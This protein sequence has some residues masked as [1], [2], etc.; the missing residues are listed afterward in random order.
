MPSDIRD[1]I[2]EETVY[3]VISLSGHD[4]TLDDLHACHLL[5]NKGRVISKF[6]ERKL[7]YS[8]Q[9]RIK[10]LQEKFLKLSKLKFSGKLFNDESMY[11]E[12]QQLQSVTKIVRLAP[13]APLFNVGCKFACSFPA[14]T[15]WESYSR[16]GTT[17]NQGAR[18]ILG[19]FEEI[20][21]L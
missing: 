21:H 5:K 1:N 2:L 17:L 11:Y 6:K 13:P 3:R 12:N 14:T 20:K 15:A 4:V 16:L 8:I 19:I 18:G 9:I 10:V 7:K